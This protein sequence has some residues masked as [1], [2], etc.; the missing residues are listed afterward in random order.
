MA[1][2]HAVAERVKVADGQ[3]LHVRKHLVAHI[4]EHAL[5]HVDH[6]AIVEVAGD[7][8]HHVDADHHAQGP[9]QAGKDGFGLQK[10]RRD[11]VVDQNADKCRAQHAGNSAEDDAQHHQQKAQTV[12]RHIAHQPADGL[13]Y[14]LGL[15]APTHS[16]APHHSLSPPF[17]WDSYTSR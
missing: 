5:R 13:A 16:H 2:D 15:Y 12:A 9:G 14:I 8:A 7:H 3:R 11:I 1:H 10:Q 17:I 6:Q 4:L